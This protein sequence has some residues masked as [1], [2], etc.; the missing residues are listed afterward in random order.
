LNLKDEQGAAAPRN[1]HSAVGVYLRNPSTG[2][3]RG[4]TGS[5]QSP[6]ASSEPHG[7]PWRGI[8][9]IRAPSTLGARHILSFLCSVFSKKAVGVRGRWPAGPFVCQKNM[10][11]RHCTSNGLF[12]APS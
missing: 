9:S 5:F 12:R 10:T 11:Q 3:H 7:A 1:Q 4:Q 8:W 6:S 2:R